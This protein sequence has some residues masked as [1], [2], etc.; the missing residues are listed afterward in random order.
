MYAWEFSGYNDKI[1]QQEE[2]VHAWHMSLPLNY[3][4][5][6]QQRENRLEIT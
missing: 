2:F 5:T 1:Q 6:T 3:V 4:T